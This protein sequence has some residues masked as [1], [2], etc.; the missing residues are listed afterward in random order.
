[1]TQSLTHPQSW[2]ETEI[3][4]SHVTHVLYRNKTFVSF[5]CQTLLDNNKFM[6]HG[7]F[8]GTNLPDIPLSLA[9]AEVKSGP[10]ILILIT[11]INSQIIQYTRTLSIYMSVCRLQSDY[12]GLK[13]PEKQSWERV[14]I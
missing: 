4:T 2:K 13:R 7:G 8:I 9:L 3:P 10:F 11:S 1:M 14:E 6:G 5:Q 12:K